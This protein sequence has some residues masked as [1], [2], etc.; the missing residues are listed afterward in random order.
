MGLGLRPDKERA[1]RQPDNDRDNASTVI[2]AVVVHRSSI[3]VI[4][5]VL[6]LIDNDLNPEP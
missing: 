1:S 6:I 5:L 2:V 3:V 4:I